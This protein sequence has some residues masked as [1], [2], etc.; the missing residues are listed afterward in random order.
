MRYGSHPQARQP[1]QAIHQA[2][3]VQRQVGLAIAAVLFAVGIAQGADLITFLRLM[4]EHGAGAEANPLVRAGVAQLG[5]LP[6]I[7]AKVALVALV[8]AV[9]AI[10]VRTRPLPGL[11]I[12]TSAT[13]AGLVGAFSNVLSL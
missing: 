7:V 5:V 6:L 9:F 3:D 2:G 10:V 13:A 4:V 12:A 1:S 11:L 8:G